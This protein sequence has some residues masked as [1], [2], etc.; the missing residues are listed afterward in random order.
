MSIRALPVATLVRANQI[1]HKFYPYIPPGIY[2]M[3]F[4]AL[5]VAT[6]ERSNVGD[7]STQG[8]TVLPLPDSGKK[9][10]RLSCT[11]NLNAPPVA[12]L[13]GSKAN[14]YDGF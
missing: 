3:R 12:T 1:I 5:P 9:Q 6:L 7:R 8:K 14:S 4:C 11:G 10:V 2:L 13:A